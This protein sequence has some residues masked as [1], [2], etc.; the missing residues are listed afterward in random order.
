MGTV[1]LFNW[2][3]RNLPD[4]Q[5]SDTLEWDWWRN[6]EERRDK[7]MQEAYESAKQY[8]RAIMCQR[9]LNSPKVLITERGV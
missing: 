2:D 1:P 8:H 7:W 5:F 4:S 6:H 3:T 9:Q